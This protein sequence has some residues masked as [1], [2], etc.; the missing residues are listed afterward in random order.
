M[1]TANWILCNV[2]PED[3]ISA[4]SYAIEETGRTAQILSLKECYGL[5]DTLD[6]S[7]ACNIFRGSLGLSVGLRTQRPNWTGSLHEIN[8]YLCSR[9]YNCWP[10]NITQQEYIFL[11]V[12]GLLR[13]WDWVFKIMNSDRLFIRP[14]SGE[15]E[16]NGEVVEAKNYNYWK[17]IVTNQCMVKMSEMA[18]ISKPVKID[19]ELRL[20]VA[21]RKVVTGSLYRENGMI[22]KTPLEDQP[23][24]QQIVTFAEDRLQE[25]DFP[26]IHCIDI[27]VCNGVYSVLEVGCFCC[28]GLYACDLV[29][30]AKGVSEIVEKSHS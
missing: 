28:C 19:R 21:N 24:W 6:E 8:P 18:V 3:R 11:P 29:K 5:L 20:I 13:K 17:H 22:F 30:I 10:G 2:G 1:T 7:H 12:G 4:L 27:A 16:F 25:A 26:L 9:Y 23:D 14:N 15:K